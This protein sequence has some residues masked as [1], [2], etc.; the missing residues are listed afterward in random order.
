MSDE[1]RP[2][3]APPGG[4]R[5]DEEGLLRT[6]LDVA[7]QALAAARAEARRRGLRPGQ[8]VQRPDREGRGD[9]GMSTG[10]RRWQRIASE[11]RSGAHPDER[12]PALLGA[13]LDRLVAE[14]GWQTDAAVG[15]VMGRWSS[16]VGA[17]VAAHVMPVSYDEGELVVAADSTAWA[18]QMRLLAPT[19]LSRLAGELGAGTVTSVRV[20]GPSAPSWKRG[21]LSVRGRGPRDTYG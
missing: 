21:R 3:S 15:G 9:P 5:P 6:G 11:E 2:D 10:R 1:P 7:R 12:D 8:P 18:T 14:R 17:E 16:I 20:Q 4:A 13:A 19:L